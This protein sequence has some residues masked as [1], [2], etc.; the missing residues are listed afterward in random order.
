ME[1]ILK[2]KKL[3]TVHREYVTKLITRVE[4]AAKDKHV[5][6]RKMKQ[7]GMQLNARM[8]TVNKMDDDILVFLSIDEDANACEKETEEVGIFQERVNIALLLIEECTN[9]DQENVHQHAEILASK[10]ARAKLPKLELKKFTGKPQDW[11][12]FWDSFCSAIEENEE[13]SVIDKFSYLRYY[14]EEPAQKVIAGFELSERNYHHA[15]ELLVK[16]F[17]RPEIIRRSHINKI[18]NAPPVYSEDDVGRLRELHDLVETHYQGLQAL[19]VNEREYSSIIVPVVLEKIPNKFR[20]HMIRGVENHENW[21]MEKMLFAFTRE[22]EIREQYIPL[23]AADDSKTRPYERK[24][25]Q[26]ETGMGLATTLLAR[27]INKKHRCAYC[28]KEHDEIDCQEVT[29]IKAKKNLIMK[30]GRCFICLKKGHRS[31][32]CRSNV[33]LLCCNC[34]GKHHTSIC[35]RERLGKPKETSAEVSVGQ[36]S[37]LRPTAPSFSSVNAS[38]CVENVGNGGRVALQTAQA[39]V[40]GKV[41][42]RV[43]VLFDSGSHRS[44][45]TSR[46]AREIGL[47]PI[48]KERFGIMTFGANEANVEER[49]IVEFSLTPTSN[50]EKRVRIEAYVVDHISDIANVH[51]ERV[52][53]DHAHLK[54]LYFSDVDKYKETLGIDILLG[55]DVLFRFQEGEI[56]RRGIDEPVAIKTLFAWVISGPI[57][58]TQLDSFYQVHLM[59]MKQDLSTA[60]IKPKRQNSKRQTT[61]T[62]GSGESKFANTFHFEVFKTKKEGNEKGEI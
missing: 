35:D 29:D 2:K 22:L 47:N 18:A 61:Q 34:G 9:V 42:A 28:L 58:R 57:K 16:R 15:K 32:E 19:G 12:E 62:R 53:Y 55:A 26:N 36:R 25:H 41:N 30:Y 51:V 33:S 39:L 3:R 45:V 8:E 49:D 20:L 13:L 43:R 10:K 52:K 38:S 50:E 59:T 54:D 21:S 4:D 6:V 37:I 60:K 24:Q 31:F 40:N 14:L 23:F 44:F 48:R 56:R 5:E 1:E 27:N 17:A 11:Q 46:V 7:F